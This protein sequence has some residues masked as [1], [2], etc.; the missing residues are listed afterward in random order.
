MKEY[1]LIWRGA[2]KGNIEHTIAAG[3]AEDAYK[4]ATEKY[5]YPEHD[6]IECIWDNGR[7]DKLFSNPHNISG[8]K[9]P[10]VTQTAET[11]IRVGW[12]DNLRNKRMSEKQIIMAQLEELR[13][14]KRVVVVFIVCAFL[15][16]VDY[17]LFNS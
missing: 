1:K 13:T 5:H 14:I 9:G 8:R 12:W 10:P 6:V 15:N 2:S 4:T 7:S 17:K 16:W 3:S 11:Y